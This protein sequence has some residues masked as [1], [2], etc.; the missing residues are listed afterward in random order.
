MKHAAF[1]AFAAACVAAAPALAQHVVTVD[2]P[3][4]VVR[5]ARAA[6]IGTGIDTGAPGAVLAQTLDGKWFT[7]TS[8]GLQPSPP[9]ATLAPANAAL[10]AAILSADGLPDGLVTTDGTLHAWLAQPTERYRHGILGDAVEAGTIALQAAN[11]PPAALALDAESVFEDLRVRLVDLTGD[12]TSEAIVVRSYAN[13]GAAL[14]V[15]AL[16]G[17]A[18]RHVAETPPIGRANRWLNP[19]GAADFD[20]DGAVEVAYVETP[21][22]GGTLRLWQLTDAGL[23][24]DF[25][26]RGFSN[27]FIGSREQD[28]AAVVDWN[29]DGVP[30][31]AVPDARRGTLRIVTFAGGQPVELAAIPHPAPIDTAVLASDAAGAAPLLIYALGDGTLR[32]ASP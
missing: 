13:A 1:A 20:G 32:L 3:G 18:V 9:P 22:I 11:R 17:A 4:P 21:H 25:A 2:Q 23:V 8:A 15:Y 14:A 30:D 19:A 24:Q 7:V 31:I 26:V 12:G 6:G 28:L 10:S 27:H 5:L 29:A 16:D